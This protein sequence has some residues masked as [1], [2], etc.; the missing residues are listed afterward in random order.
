MNKSILKGILS[1]L[2]GVIVF[3][4]LFLWQKDMEL[5]A[6]FFF[7]ITA[8]ILGYM[9][10]SPLIMTNEERKYFESKFDKWF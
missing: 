2:I 7:S 3:G 9:V 8:A 1:V 4:F 6:N 5:M 10:I